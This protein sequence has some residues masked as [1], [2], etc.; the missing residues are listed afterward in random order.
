MSQWHDSGVREEVAVR[1]RDV[2][3]MEREGGGSGE[4]VEAAMD[5]RETKRQERVAR[6]VERT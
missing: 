6:S 1:G 3:E 2:R 5:L 4:R